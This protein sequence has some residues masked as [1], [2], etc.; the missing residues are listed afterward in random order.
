MATKEA[1]LKEARLK[2]AAETL[3]EVKEQMIELLETARKALR[4]TDEED[5]AKGYWWAHIRCALDND[6]EYLGGSMT[7]MQDSIDALTEAE[8]LAAPEEDEEE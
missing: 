1:R 6:H 8:A 5:R 3:L 4:G 7:T 2:E